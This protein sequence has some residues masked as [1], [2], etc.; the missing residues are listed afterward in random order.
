MG[1]NLLEQF[2]LADRFTVVSFTLVVAFILTCVV[3]G[4]YQANVENPKSAL[5]R[6]FFAMA[7]V[8]LWMIIISVIVESGVVA[9]QPFPRIPLFFAFMNIC[10]VVFAFSRPG[11]WLMALPL[12]ALVGFQAFRL[13]LELILHSW[14]EQGTVP[15]TMTW[16]GQNLDIITGISAVIC[17]P[18]SVKYVRAAQVFN[19]IGFLLLMNV[20][21]VAMMSS[22]LPFAWGVQPTLQ[23]VL[24]LPYAWIGSVCV[25]GALA[26]HLILFRKLKT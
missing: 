22:P 9:E 3:F 16:T 2:K 8:F 12:W 6:S 13:P 17:A 4:I 26:G 14:A 1:E 21:R 10:A 24:H 7:G 23:L 18:L 5:R 11:K 20:M 19:I 15:G 25:A